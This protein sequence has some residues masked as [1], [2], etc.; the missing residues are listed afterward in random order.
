MN[1]M[2]NEDWNNDKL[3]DGFDATYSN[4]IY[5]FDWDGNPVKKYIIDH[6]SRN[7]WVDENDQAIYATTEDLENPDRGTVF[8]RYSL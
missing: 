8:L 3:T 7:F 6:R 1:D 4:E 2:T 5:V